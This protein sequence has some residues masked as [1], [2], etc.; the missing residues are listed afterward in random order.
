MIERWD[1]GIECP[2]PENAARIAPFEQ[3]LQK[4]SSWKGGKVR[5]FDAI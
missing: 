4:L 1:G 3:G 2:D 5:S